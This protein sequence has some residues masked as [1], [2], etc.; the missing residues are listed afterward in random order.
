METVLRV[1]ALCL[2]GC[3]LTQLLK[4]DVPV[5]Q[6]LLTVGIVL[7]LAMPSVM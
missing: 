2:I 5:M 4:K 7:V 3:V 6:L 1:S